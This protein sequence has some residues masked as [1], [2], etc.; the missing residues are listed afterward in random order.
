[1]EKGPV[2]LNLVARVK[3]HPMYDSRPMV[4]EL[5]ESIMAAQPEKIQRETS[6]LVQQQSQDVARK[7]VQQKGGFDAAKVAGAAATKRADKLARSGLGERP[8]VSVEVGFDPE[9]ESEVEIGHQQSVASNA[10]EVTV[11]APESNKMSLLVRREEEI[12]LAEGRV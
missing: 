5:L 6:K 11:Q 1:M 8:W 9:E 2:S 12:F 3:A 4:K 10:T 7:Q